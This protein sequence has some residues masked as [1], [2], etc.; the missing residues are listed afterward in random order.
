VGTGIDSSYPGAGGALSRQ[1]RTIQTMKLE[2][3]STVI[4]PDGVEA[5]MEDVVI[6]PAAKQISHL[7]LYIRHRSGDARLVPIEE[8]SES[9]G[10]LHCN[11]ALTEFPAVES[12][13]FVKLSSPVDIAGDWDVGI[14]EISALPYYRAEFDD[15]GT[16]WTLETDD[17]V[18]IT[19]HRIP[20]HRVEIRR[21]SEVTDA[22]DRTI[23][24]VDGFVVDDADHVTHLVLEKG[25]LWGR[26]DIT[27]PIGLV[28]ATTSDRVR[29]SITAR[30]V[31]ALPRPRVHALWRR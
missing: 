2:L 10:R 12:T 4:L 16:P 9:D 31:E 6:D 7:V 13:Q 28:A 25:H 11:R 5:M 19:F 29:L 27:I 21:R 8:I 17:E 24:H 15:M 30:E 26:H 14:E 23:G 3:N 22:E 20:K 18:G 1:R